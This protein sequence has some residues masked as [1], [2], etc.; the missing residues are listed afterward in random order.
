MDMLKLRFDLN[1]MQRQSLALRGRNIMLN[2]PTGSGKTEAFLL[3]LNER[4]IA[5]LLLP[6]ITSCVFMYQRLVADFDN[7]N[8]IIKTSLLTDKRMVP[9]AL[10]SIEIMCPDGP[11]TDYLDH[12]RGSTGTGG[13]AGIGENTG[14]NSSPINPFSGNCLILD[15]IDNYPVMVKTALIEFLKDFPTLHVIVASATIDNVL[16][17]IFKGLGII[18][19]VYNQD[20]KLIKHK[21]GH[22]KHLHYIKDIVTDNS[23]KKIGIICNTINEMWNV[24]GFLE[25]EKYIFHHAQL[26]EYERLENEKRLFT[27]DFRLVI[28]NDLIAYSV[29]IDFDILIMSLSDKLSIN[30]QRIGRNNRYNKM[31]LYKNL[32]I[33]DPNIFSAPPF[34]NEYA[35]YEQLNYFQDYLSYQR[36]REL[37][38][39]LEPEELP[40][41]EHIYKYWTTLE[42]KGLEHNL[43]EVPIT[44]ELDTK[45]DIWE[46]NEVTKR[47]E[48]K[49]V[50]TKLL[51]KI[52]EELPYAFSYSESGGYLYT[53]EKN[54]K[55]DNRTLLYLKGK[56]YEILEALPNGRLKIAEYNGEFYIKC[57][58]CGKGAPANGFF[59]HSGTCIYCNKRPRK[60][61]RR[62][63]H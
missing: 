26:T 23:N 31:V 53:S 46:F 44:L 1:D 45:L 39:E 56:R 15:E 55:S 12:K 49:T 43:R 57:P 33:I 18:E 27:G 61:R 42:Q 28:S 32:F 2:A 51:I 17:N 8:V 34:I 54:A 35:Q 6:T 59:A 22:I 20:I 40:S 14:D 9:R 36:I 19:I 21:I 4:E 60:K 58:N 52:N 5:T 47:R 25:S 29:D 62:R 16:G 37:R 13:A 30:L 48:K 38:S 3:N 63:R 41:L 50:D 7:I 10:F 24:A 11:L